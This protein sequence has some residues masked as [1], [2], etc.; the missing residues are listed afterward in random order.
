VRSA[1]DQLSLELTVRPLADLGDLRLVRVL[2]WR[3]EVAEP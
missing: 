3:A 2:L 1:A